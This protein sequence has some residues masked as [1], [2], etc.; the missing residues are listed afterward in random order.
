MEQTYHVFGL[1]LW[2]KSEGAVENDE[3]EIGR[4]VCSLQPVY[5]S[6]LELV[7]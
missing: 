5:L 2:E 1:R 7:R 4:P 6:V 3:K